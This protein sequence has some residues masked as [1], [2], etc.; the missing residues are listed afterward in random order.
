[1]HDSEIFF[2]EVLPTEITCSNWHF[3]RFVYISKVVEVF[4]WI[5]DACWIDF[6]DAT[7]YV[8]SLIT[9]HNA[10]TVYRV[11]NG[12]VNKTTFHNETNCILYPCVS[13]VIRSNN[14]VCVWQC[15]C[16]VGGELPFLLLIHSL[17]GLK[18][19][20]LT[21]VLHV[22]DLYI[23]IQL[24]SLEML[25]MISQWPQALCSTK[26]CCGNYRFNLSPLKKWWC[27]FVS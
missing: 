9:A 13:I 16:D 24:T 5:L 4:D 11:T 6:L 25:W 17:Y 1:M 19:L 12:T 10:V 2:I 3:T 27:D 26:S 21:A 20:T 8:V 14:N 22:C 18:E 15:V 7:N 23:V